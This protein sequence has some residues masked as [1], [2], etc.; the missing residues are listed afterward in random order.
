MAP[1]ALLSLFLLAV[2]AR[3][4]EVQTA[5]EVN[6]I[7]AQVESGFSIDSSNPPY[8]DTEWYWEGTCIQY[9]GQCTS[10]AKFDRSWIETGN[11][12]A[13]YVSNTDASAI[14]LTNDP[15]TMTVTNS[16]STMD[17]TTSGWTIGA[18]LSGSVSGDSVTGGAEVSASY[19]QSSTTS[20][21]VTTT[22]SYTATCPAQ[23]H[24]SVETW[25]FHLNITGSCLSHGMINCRSLGTFDQCTNPQTACQQYQDM[26]TYHCN[27]PLK[28]CN[29]QTPVYNSDGTTPYSQIVL[30]ATPINGTSPIERSGRDQQMVKYKVIG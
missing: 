6:Q 21:T 25:T 16:T 1:R 13:F 30:I 17:S 10:T 22:V 24:C 23:H 2:A 7:L 11:A 5:A 9:F 4:Q 28:P 26:Y 14:N 12:T 15:S 3:S 19:S 20:T 18:K 8:Y 27:Q 29:V